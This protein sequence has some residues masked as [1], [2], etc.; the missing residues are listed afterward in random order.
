MQPDPGIGTVG[1]SL[2]LL[3]YAFL[4]HGALLVNDGL[5][6]DGWVVDS[7]Q[8][9]KDWKNMRRFFR[10]TGMP[11]LYY[12]HKAMSFFPNRVFGYRLVAFAST[13]VSALAVYL[14]AARFGFM[15][16]TLAL[17][18]GL[19]YLAYTGYHMNVDTVVGLQY[20]FPTAVFHV[21][22]YLAFTA[23]VATA[24]WS[25]LAHILAVLLFLFSFN[26]NSLL[27]YHFVFVGLL[28][29]S[30]RDVLGYG[31]G[32]PRLIATTLVYGVLP[33]SY[34]VAKEKLT[35][36]HG[37]YAEYNRVKLSA[38]RLIRGY[39]VLMRKGVEAAA[40][41]PFRFLVRR[42][43]L[44]VPV[45]VAAAVSPG[46]VL[47]GWDSSERAVATGFAIFALGAA[48]FPYLAVGLKFHESGWGTKQ[49]MLLHLPAAL[50]ALTVILA[51]PESGRS[52]ILL[53][54]LV[55]NALWLTSVYSHHL[56]VY[57]KNLSWLHHLRAIPDIE[58]VK[59]LAVTDQHW[60]QG[61]EENRSQEHRPAYLFAMFSRLW[62]DRTH[63][64]IGEPDP[65][66]DCYSSAELEREVAGTTQSYEMQSVAVDG[67]Q[68]ALI[69]R[70]GELDSVSEICVR[71]L[72]CRLLRDRVGMN[73][74]LDQAATV[75]FRLL[76]PE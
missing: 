38:G 67:Q 49:S 17:A 23:Q 22:A 1:A 7:W 70:S 27:A 56:A 6:W 3:G 47:D 57:V 12:K 46:Y 61:D 10:E 36:R 50:L 32:D 26:A 66:R 52:V 59:V 54:V 35:P 11:L 15:D 24:P 68:G 58:N 16:E 60:L 13:Y 29:W 4:A 19:L 28:V 44:W 42:N 72:R 53:F 8:E 5:Y 43:L 34:W 74:L 21:A 9:R 20:T 30:V 65:R 51:M 45:L 69:V 41:L 55:A 73:A 75:D 14:I 40:T 18:L 48:G 2:V 71:Y 37:D 63:F 31:L 64:G 25:W 62:P 76:R 33:I 39:L